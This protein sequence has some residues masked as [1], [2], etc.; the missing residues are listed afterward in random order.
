MT[1]R[2]RIEQVIAAEARCKDKERAWRHAR[3]AAQIAKT[4]YDIATNDLICLVRDALRDQAE[5]L[6][7]TLE[8]TN[9]RD[10]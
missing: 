1:T 5:A 3:D 7:I 2:Q 9:E 4:E 10:V 8:E 6:G